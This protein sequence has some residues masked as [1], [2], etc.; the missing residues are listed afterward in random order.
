MKKKTKIRQETFYLW[1]KILKDSYK[2]KQL[3][4]LIY[5][6][7][8]E[9]VVSSVNNRVE[10]KRSKYGIFDQGRKENQRK[11]VRVLDHKS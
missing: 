1:K 3:G 2:I 5:H 6:E 9:T 4:T 7:V 8:I 10:V 11:I